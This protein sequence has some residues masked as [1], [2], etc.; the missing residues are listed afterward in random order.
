MYADLDIGKEET[1][2]T[3]DARIANIALMVRDYCLNND[4][5]PPDFPESMS[6]EQTIRSLLEREQLTDLECF[7]YVRSME[8]VNPHLNEDVSLSRMTQIIQNARKR[9][10]L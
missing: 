7:N 3:N 6:L 2:S 5:S 10:G 4:L 1:M 9:R 8:D